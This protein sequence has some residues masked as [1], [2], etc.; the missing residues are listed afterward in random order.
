MD[1][2]SQK[3]FQHKVLKVGSSYQGARESF[4]SIVEL[5]YSIVALWLCEK[6]V[7]DELLFLL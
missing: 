6:F 3:A 4:E 1:F 2:F 7:G 5:N